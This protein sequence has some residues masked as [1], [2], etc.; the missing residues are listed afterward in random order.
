[1]LD[2]STLLMPGELA[3]RESIPAGW[4]PDPLGADK[5]RWWDG[6][7]W[8]Q[9][10]ATRS[11]AGAA[12]AGRP[13]QAQWPS[14]QW[15]Q[16]QWPQASQ[17]Q[18]SQAQWPSAGWPSGSSGEGGQRAGL[19]GFD[20]SPASQPG[21]RSRETMGFGLVPD[22]EQY[23]GVGTARRRGSPADPVEPGHAYVPMA[24]NTPVQFRPAQGPATSCTAAVWTIALLPLA[25]LAIVLLLIFGVSN[26]GRFLQA[27]VGLVFFLC[28]AM[29][30]A[31][32]RRRLIVAG[33]TRTASAW[34][35][36][37]SPLAYLVVRSVCVHR[38]TGRGSSPLWAYV[39]CSVLPVVVAIVLLTRAGA[40]SLVAAAAQQ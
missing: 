14:V 33:H 23:S 24:V 27:G 26:F 37:L 9:H 19:P 31:H 1:M 7:A 40:L 38:E 29:L 18:G 20:P 2:E 8:T 13:S 25:E 17:T 11:A 10:V 16:A 22:H 3:E 32:D 4:Y 12:P 21:S 34:W 6:T 5:R 35:T 15:S 36:V 30:A 28:S 39:A